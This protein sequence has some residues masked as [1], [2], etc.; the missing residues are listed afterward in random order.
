MA[1]YKVGDSKKVSVFTEEKSCALCKGAVKHSIE[2]CSNPKEYKL[3]C[4][5]FAGDSDTIG[6]Q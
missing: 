1:F 3:E 6:I 5:S 4:A 2:Q